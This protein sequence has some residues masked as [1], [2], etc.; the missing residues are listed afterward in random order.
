LCQIGV[1]KRNRAQSK[2]VDPVR[3]RKLSTKQ[4][5]D[6]MRRHPNGQYYYVDSKG[7]KGM[8]KKTALAPK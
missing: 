2:K 4:L 3:E 8:N 5:P 6:G 1:P 7:A